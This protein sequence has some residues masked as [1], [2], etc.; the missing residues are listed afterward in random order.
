V[1]HHH[2]TILDKS[3]DPA[4]HA[5]EPARRA[6]MSLRGRFK[7]SCLVGGFAAI[8]ATSVVGTADMASATPAGR[9]L[10]SPCLNFRS[11]ASGTSTLVNCIPVNVTIAIDCTA[12][13]TAVTGPYGTTTL[14]DHTVYN[15]Q[16]GYVSDAWVY[17]GSANAVAGTCAAPPPPA[18]TPAPTSGR[19][20]GLKVSTNLGVAGYCTWGALEQWRANTGYY[21]SWS[22]D[23]MYW[24]STAKRNGWTVVPNA[25]TRSIVVFQPGVQGARSSGHVGWVTSVDNRADGRYI[26]FIEMNGT[27]GFNK[28]DNR[29]VKDIAGMSYILAP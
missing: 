19:T 14:W 21:P 22:G 9:V 13:G 2:T 25:E 12:N 27:A 17:T 20:I 26:T 1:K 23:A 15:G 11:A 5:V 8:V 29:T 18:P 3:G 6:T 16:A 4:R 28:W 24:A 10:A 7:R